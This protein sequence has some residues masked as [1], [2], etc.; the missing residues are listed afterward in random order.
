MCMLDGSNTKA[1]Q[2]GT[3]VDSPAMKA[4]RSADHNELRY[5]LGNKTILGHFYVIKIVTLVYI[6][7][8]VICVKLDPDIHM[9][10]I[11][12]CL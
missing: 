7:G 2:S 9:R 3:S 10:C 11:W 1:G 6:H 8:V 12:I 4:G 5:V